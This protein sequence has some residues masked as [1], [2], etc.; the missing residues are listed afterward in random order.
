MQG[1][2]CVNKEKGWT[3]FDVVKK[4]KRIFNTSKVGHLGTLDPMAEGVLPVA[5][6]KA[7]KLFDLYLHKT[8]EYIAEFEFGYETDSLDLE[9]TIINRSKIIPTKEQVGNALPKFIGKQMQVPPKYSAIKINGRRAYDLARKDIDFSPE[10]KEIEIHN[11]SCLEQVSQSKFK[12][13]IEC[14]AGTYIRSIAR[15]LAR[16]LN[17]VATM[18]A[19]SRTRAG[20][21]D[22][23][24]SKTIAEI[25][26]TPESNLI[27]LDIAL[28]DLPLMILPQAKERLVKNGVKIR[29]NNQTENQ[30]SRVYIQDELIGVG[31]IIDGQLQLHIRLYE[32]EN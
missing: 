22:I 20:S 2:V 5:I 17:T 21:F 25:E 1:I 7:T 14:S 9:G 16:E 11:I 19:L 8:K 13:Q 27:S 24:T 32:G 6:G 29:V 31:E 28:G 4:I 18:T 10:A 15:D 3:S 12:F 23:T 26:E 30:L